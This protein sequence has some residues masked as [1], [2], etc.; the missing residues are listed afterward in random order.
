MVG[1]RIVGVPCALEHRLQML[2]E[3]LQLQNVLSME[4]RQTLL[5]HLALI[6]TTISSLNMVSLVKMSIK[7]N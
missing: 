3:A 7:K 4:D 2:D 6:K 5:S 1:E